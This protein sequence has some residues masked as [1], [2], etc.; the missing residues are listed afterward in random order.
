MLEIFQSLKWR[1]GTRSL[2][3]H[4]LC[5][6]SCTLHREG[7]IFLEQTIVIMLDDGANDD[8]VYK[9]TLLVCC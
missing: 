1:R 8:D 4:S 2:P 6:L 3:R 9:R 5:T 7:L